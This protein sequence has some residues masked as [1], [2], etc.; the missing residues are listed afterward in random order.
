MVARLNDSNGKKCGVIHECQNAAVQ[1]QRER[2]NLE[3]ARALQTKEAAK[4][5]AM[6]SLLPEAE[7]DRARTLR[8]KMTKEN[9]M[10]A[11][12]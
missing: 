11:R 7:M 1:Q 6:K 9:R 12:V 2:W 10:R 5:Y 3:A 4:V 8:M